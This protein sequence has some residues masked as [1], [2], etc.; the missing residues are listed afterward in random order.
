MKVLG[1]DT[2]LANLGWALVEMTDE[3]LTLLH[4]GTVQTKKSTRRV[5]VSHDRVRRMQEQARYLMKEVPFEEAVAVVFEEQ[6][7]PRNATNCAM[8]GMSWGL[9]VLLCEQLKLPVL[10]AETGEIKKAVTN[11]KT[12]S[13]PEM[14]TWLRA[15]PGFENIAEF[16]EGLPKTRREHPVDACGA[17]IAMEHHD[18]LRALLRAVKSSEAA[19]PPKTPKAASEAP[20]ARQRKAPPPPPARRK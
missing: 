12:A 10:Q 17:V 3:G 4:A 19:E 16:L 18:T 7:W 8:I 20:Q 14:E 5:R 15:R 9:C 11:K 6:S 1:I 2:G 13:K